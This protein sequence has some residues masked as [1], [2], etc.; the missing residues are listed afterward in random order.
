MVLNGLK[1]S[2]MRKGTSKK[3]SKLHKKLKN[4]PNVWVIAYID[5]KFIKN[6]VYELSKYPEYAEVEAYIPTV[7]ILK[8]TFKKEN[9][10]E[11]VPLLFNYGFFKVPR[12]Y[13]IYKNWLD[14]LQKNV[15]CIYGWV[16]DPANIW[17]E[18]PKMRLDNES[19]YHTEANR[20]SAATASSAD[21]GRLI[22]DTINLGAHS[23]EEISLLQEG[24]EIVLR[25]Y[26]FE[27]V[28]AR[29][30][31]INHK[32]EE[33]QVEIRIFD[34][35]RPALVSFDN[36]FFTIYHNTKNFDDALTGD[37]SIDE[38]STNKTFDKIQKKNWRDDIK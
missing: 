25:G 23:S 28:N 22:K 2:K 1:K 8:K 37:K 9:I 31:S 16:R 19:V 12:K 34:Q 13:A 38:M 10:F 35:M 27:G 18:A 30:L 11:E 7:K 21:I 29:V 36:V 14:N 4:D 17:T 6:V 20:I 15:S 33:V 32:T 3:R 26:P 24:Q 5:A